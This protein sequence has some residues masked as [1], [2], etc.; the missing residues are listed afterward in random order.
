M[1]EGQPVWEFVVVAEEEVLD[2]A[3]G[4]SGSRASGEPAGL[5]MQNCAGRQMQA[6][7][8]AGKK[9]GVRWDHAEEV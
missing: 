4:A 1:P 3:A 6:V 5:E 9:Q 7:V 2:A 8:V